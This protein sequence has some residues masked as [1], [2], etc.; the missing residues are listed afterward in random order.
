MHLER[1]TERMRD[2]V[3]LKERDSGRLREPERAIF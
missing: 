1:I 2:R 3:R